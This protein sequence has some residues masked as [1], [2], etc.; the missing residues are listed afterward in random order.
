MIKKCRKNVKFRH[1][2]QVL[3]WNTEF[4]SLIMKFEQFMAS[5]KLSLNVNLEMLGINRIDWCGVFV[6][7]GDTQLNRA[8]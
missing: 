5:V 7:R 8:D 6:K 2:G 3:K 1:L 4:V